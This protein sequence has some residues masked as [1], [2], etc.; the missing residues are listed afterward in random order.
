M[1]MDLYI[2]CMTRKGKGRTNVCM[3]VSHTSIQL[4]L[5]NSSTSQ[6]ILNVH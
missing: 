1:D 5:K 2:F 4:E 6:I 3:M